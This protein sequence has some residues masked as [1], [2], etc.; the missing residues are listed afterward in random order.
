M[1][2]LKIPLTEESFDDEKLEFIEPEYFPLQFEHSLASLSKWESKFEKPFL[3]DN[4]KTTEEIL[5]YY[6]AMLLTENPPAGIL[7]RLSEADYVL[8]N[9]YINAKMTATTFREQAK[10]GPRSIITAE[11][12]YYFMV[13]L[14]IPFECQHW[15]LKRLLTLIEVCNQ[16]NAPAKKMSPEEQAREMRALNERRRAEMGTR[17]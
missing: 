12:I 5:W 11:L 9:E 8:I 15:H 17:G 2:T 6:E 4:E 7:G 3:S 10:T 13:A 16:K 14:N 1:L